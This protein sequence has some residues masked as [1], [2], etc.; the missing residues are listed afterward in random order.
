MEKCKSRIEWLNEEAFND[1]TPITR[2][3]QKEKSIIN[4]VN[5]S[6]IIRNSTSHLNN[7]ITSNN[8]IS[9]RERT[10]QELIQD[11]P[12]VRTL[13]RIKLNLKRQN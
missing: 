6:S 8:Q 5:E 3:W 2:Y 10:R 11:I 12:L 7:T 4:R 13:K 1:F 9:K